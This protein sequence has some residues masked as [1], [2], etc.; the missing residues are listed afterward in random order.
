M[1]WKK[2]HITIYFRLHALLKDIEINPFMGGKGKTEALKGVSN[3]NSKRITD[4]HRITY[5]VKGKDK[6]KVITILSCK[7]HYGDK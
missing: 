7:G 3:R 6:N 1:E 5:S 4:G 2:N